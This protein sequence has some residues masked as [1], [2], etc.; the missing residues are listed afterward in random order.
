MIALGEKIGRHPKSKLIGFLTRFFQFV[1]RLMD[2]LKK[3][4]PY[5]FI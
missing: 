1:A 2:Q 3:M 4:N 5:L